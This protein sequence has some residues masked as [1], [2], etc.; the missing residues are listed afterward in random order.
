ML[1]V[2]LL[3]TDRWWICNKSLHAKIGKLWNL[4]SGEV[5]VMVEKLGVVTKEFYLD[6]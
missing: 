4:G 6:L 5:F 2:L 3:H 1:F